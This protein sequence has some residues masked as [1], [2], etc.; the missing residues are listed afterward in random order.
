MRMKVSEEWTE[1]KTKKTL[2]VNMPSEGLND[3]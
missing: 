2:I 3:T 1:Q